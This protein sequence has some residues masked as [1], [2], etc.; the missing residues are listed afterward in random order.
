MK[1]RTFLGKEKETSYDLRSHHPQ[2]LQGISQQQKAGNM[3]PDRA[4]IAAAG[5]KSHPV[6]GD[7]GEAVMKTKKKYRAVKALDSDYKLVVNL[8]FSKLRRAIRRRSNRQRGNPTYQDQP[9]KAHPKKNADEMKKNLTVS[10]ERKGDEVLFDVDSPTPDHSPASATAATIEAIPSM[11]TE[12]EQPQVPSPVGHGVIYS[13]DIEKNEKC[14]DKEAFIEQLIRYTSP[15]HEGRTTNSP[16]ASSFE[17]MLGLVP[18]VETTKAVSHQSPKDDQ[19]FHIQDK[20]STD[21]GQKTDLDDV[22]RIGS[23]NLSNRHESTD[24]T[25]ADQGNDLFNR[26]RLEL[27]ELSKTELIPSSLPRTVERRLSGTSAPSSSAFEIKSLPPS[28][29]QPQSMNL[30]SRNRRTTMT[31]TLCR[32]QARQNSRRHSVSGSIVRRTPQKQ[33]QAISLN[34]CEQQFQAKLFKTRGLCSLCVHRLSP[35]EKQGLER[36][37][38]SIRV[39]EA[40]GGCAD[41]TIFSEKKD[42][43]DLKDAKKSEDE[44]N[45][46]PVRLCR[47]CFYSTHKPCK[48]KD[49]PFKYVSS[50]S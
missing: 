23:P 45:S 32:K 9:S 10:T 14:I 44:L 8:G 28:P 11:N 24:P 38:R 50:L 27:P 48:R 31:P 34:T 41:C 49:E 19:L 13:K 12:E 29:H 15:K 37:G 21:G 39:R 17:T 46:E 6:D 20:K 47:Q 36:T 42:G 35:S 43:E 16:Q 3:N 4:S 1:Q 5:P 33:Y 22:E 7:N 30:R 26:E 25:K 2:K 40:Y 18:I